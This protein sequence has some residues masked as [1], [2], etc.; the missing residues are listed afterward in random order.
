MTRRAGLGLLAGAGVAP[1]VARGLGGDI[2]IGALLSLTGDWSTLGITSKALL[3]IAV[4]EIN[5]FFDATSTPGRVTLRVEDTK[6]DPAA[7]VNGLRSLAGA[8][9]KLVIGP[10]SSGCLLGPLVALHLHVGFVEVRKDRG[11]SGDSDAWL[12]RTTPPDYQ[13][14]H[15]S[16]GFRKRLITG[17]D[18]VLFVDDWIE[19]GGQAHSAHLLTQDAEA[20]RD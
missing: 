17:G 13:D 3:E 15:L 19:T 20:S 2:T 18:R 11:P 4:A 14:R 1:L 7:A 6:L 5:A 16:L 12:R 10:Q 9:A 8:G